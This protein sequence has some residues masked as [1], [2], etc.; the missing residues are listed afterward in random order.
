MLELLRTGAFRRIDRG[1]SPDIS[2]LPG[3]RGEVSAANPSRGAKLLSNDVSTIP[4]KRAVLIRKSGYRF[5]LAT[6]AKA[7]AF[8]PISIGTELALECAHGSKPCACRGC[9]ARSWIVRTLESGHEWLSS[10]SHRAQG[11]TNV[12]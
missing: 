11:E 12:G 1:S 5:S 8:V 6:N 2:D 3:D 4:Q 10:Q 7:G 9:R